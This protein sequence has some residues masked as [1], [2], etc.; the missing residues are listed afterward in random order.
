MVVTKQDAVRI[1]SE[2][3]DAIIKPALDSCQGKN[4][5]RFTSE[6]GRINSTT[7]I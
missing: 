1:C 2:L 5:V 7:A 3:P 6:E 4:V